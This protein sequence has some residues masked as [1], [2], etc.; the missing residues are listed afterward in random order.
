MDKK[1]IEGQRACLV[2]AIRDYAREQ[3]A[4]WRRVPHLAL[5]AEGRAEHCE[6]R[7][8]AY[9]YGVWAVL[10]DTRDRRL[11]VYVDLATGELVDAYDF[12]RNRVCTPAQDSEVL[13]IALAIG[14]LDAYALVAELEAKGR[15]A[16]ASFYV[17]TR[18]DEWR[19]GMR[20]KHGVTKVYDPKSRK[21]A[22][23]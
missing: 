9:V 4:E 18:Q 12:E 19:D 23:P 22:R 13:K 1:T 3:V 16:Y 10:G 2:T 15:V 5:E 8:R 14:Q 17:A 20:R 6:N 11:A 21:L 7:A